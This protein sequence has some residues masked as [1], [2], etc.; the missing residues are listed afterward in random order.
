MAVI[1]A[2]GLMSLGCAYPESTTRGRTESPSIQV[3][4]APEGSVLVVDGI[5]AGP[6]AEFAKGKSLAVLPGRHVVE[7]RLAGRS[8][9][10]REVFV[11]SQGIKTVDFSG[12]GQ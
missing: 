11:D 2:A 5:E 6:A 1:L 7:L 3:L 10:K 4:G 9:V 8:L 12:V